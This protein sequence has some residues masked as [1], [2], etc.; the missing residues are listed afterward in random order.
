MMNRV[1]VEA[2]RLSAK[3]KLPLPPTLFGIVIAWKC[4]Y[5]SAV[6]VAEFLNAKKRGVINCKSKF[7]NT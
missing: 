4:D 1:K 3:V 2:P 6:H 5:N 7:F